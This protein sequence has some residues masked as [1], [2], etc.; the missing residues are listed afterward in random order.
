M[1][2]YVSDSKAFGLTHDRVYGKYTIALTVVPIIYSPS[3]V[4]QWR[5]Q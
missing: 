4:L 2:S 5:W 1:T 3:L